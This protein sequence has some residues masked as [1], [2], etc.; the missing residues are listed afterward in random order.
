MGKKKK[1]TVSRARN[2]NLHGCCH[3]AQDFFQFFNVFLGL[4]KLVSVRLM[5]RVSRHGSVPEN[6]VGA[7]VKPALCHTHLALHN[8]QQPVLDLAVHPISNSADEVCR[9]SLIGYDQHDARDL[10]FALLGYDADKV[11]VVLLL[12]HVAL[13]NNFFQLFNGCF[14]GC[15]C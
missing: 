12:F 3:N 4:R 5:A 11:T 7:R 2:A 15:F 6:T 8:E 10:L 13:F 1:R 14:N 9:R